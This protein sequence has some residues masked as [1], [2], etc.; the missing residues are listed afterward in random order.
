MKIL[1]FVKNI[2]L[3]LLLI[4]GLIIN[5]IIFFFVKEIW[6]Y[7]TSPWE[8]FSIVKH[9]DLKNYIFDGLS[10]ADN[11]SGIIWG[12][13]RNDEFLSGEDWSVTESV[14]EESGIILESKDSGKNWR[15]IYKSENKIISISQVTDKLF[16]AL[17][18]IPPK[19]NSR[20]YFQ[21]LKFENDSKSFI[22]LS[23]IYDPVVWSK[24]F[25]FNSEVGFIFGYKEQYSNLNVMMTKDGGKNWKT[26]KLNYPP[27]NFL[28]DRDEPFIKYDDNNLCYRSDNNLI[29]L[30][31]NSMKEDVIEFPKE[32][33][34]ISHFCLDD[35]K[36]LWLLGKSYSD[37][38]ALFKQKDNNDFEKIEPSLK[39]IDNDKKLTKFIHIYNNT[40]YIF[41]WDINGFLPSWK[42]Y[43]SADDGLTWKE[44]KIPQST[45]TNLI[46]LYKDN[47]WIHAFWDGKLQYR[48]Y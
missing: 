26:V 7:Y 31:I 22:N 16:Y 3:G 41:L 40:I 35:N 12:E 39:N 37:A 46:A 32:A 29:L 27:V 38:I 6:Y 20:G 44:E 14:K 10:F 11:K 8:Q 42:L 13:Y 30:D 9:D 19:D 47:V 2:V 28:T 4:A 43:M 17:E 45:G 21:I 1:K 5:L 18:E 15:Q 33:V 24:I 25:F 34:H 23:K 48:H 36:R